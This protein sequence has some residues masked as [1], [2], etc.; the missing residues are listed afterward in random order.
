MHPLVQLAC[1][2]VNPHIAA[3]WAVQSWVTAHRSLSQISRQKVVLLSPSYDPVDYANNH[4][5]AAAM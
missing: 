5:H 3:A 2:L 1:H 4:D